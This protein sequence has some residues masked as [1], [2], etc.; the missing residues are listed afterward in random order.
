MWS[1]VVEI[2]A[3]STIQNFFDLRQ[4]QQPQ[5]KNVKIQS[6]FCSFFVQILRNFLLILSLH[7]SIYAETNSLPDK[8]NNR[9]GFCSFLWN[10]TNLDGTKSAVIPGIFLV[11]HSQNK[12]KNYSK[13]E[14]KLSKNNFEFWHFLSEAAEAVWGQKSFEWLIRHKFPLLRTTPSL[15]KRPIIQN[16]SH[17]STSKHQVLRWNIL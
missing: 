3:W 11:I 1:W 2:Y 7:G 12:K 10:Q 9:F 8:L 17:T 15:I 14:Q 13:F 5:I 6:C 4:P 16:P